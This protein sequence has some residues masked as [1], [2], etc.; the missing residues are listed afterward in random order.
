M[1]PNRT[2]F[3]GPWISDEIETRVGFP[4]FACETL[5]ALVG[6]HRRFLASAVWE[7][8]SAV[9]PETERQPV[10]PVAPVARM[11]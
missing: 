7:A 11:A 9:L 8:L 3:D 2:A 1:I 6:G 10:T 5:T 4:A